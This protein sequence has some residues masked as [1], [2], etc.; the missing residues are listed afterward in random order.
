MFSYFFKWNKKI[1]SSRGSRFDRS[2]EWFFAQSLRLDHL[3][4]LIGKFLGIG[5]IWEDCF[6]LHSRNR[7]RYIAFHSI[8]RLREAQSPR[9]SIGKI[10]SYSYRSLGKVELRS[11]RFICSI[12]NDWSTPNRII[13][14]K[15]SRFLDYLISV[16]DWISKK[17]LLKTNQ[18]ILLAFS[19]G[20]DS[21]V[22][23]F[24]I[25]QLKKQW[26]WT[27]NLIWCNHLWQKDS[28]YLMFHI[29]KVNLIFY[30]K[31]FCFIN[32]RSIFSENKA[33]KWRYQIFIRAA[34][35]Y[36]LT[37]ILT[38][39]TL[40]DKIE[41]LIFNLTRGCG[42]DGFYSLNKLSFITI[43]KY[44]YIFPS[45]NL[46]KVLTQKLKKTKTFDYWTNDCAK[47]NSPN[48]VD[49]WSCENRAGGIEL[50]SICF[51]HFVSLDRTKWKYWVGFFTENKTVL[52]LS[53]HFKY[54][55]KNSK[56]ISY[57]YLIM[58]NLGDFASRNLFRRQLEL[59]QRRFPYLGKKPFA[60]IRRSSFVRSGEW[61]VDQSTLFNHKFLQPKSL[62]WGNCTSGNWSDV[63]FLPNVTNDCAKRN[64]PENVLLR[65]SKE[66]SIKRS[67]IDS[68]GS[69]KPKNFQNFSRT[70]KK[71]LNFGNW[72]NCVSSNWSFILKR[73]VSFL[74]KKS[75]GVGSSFARSH[76]SLDA[77]QPELC[78][79]AK[80]PEL[81]SG[82][83][84]SCFASLDSEELNQPLV[85]CTKRVYQ[86]TIL[87]RL[88][89]FSKSTKLTIPLTFKYA[90]IFTP[91]HRANS[92]NYYNKVL[93]MKS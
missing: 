13:Q 3:A 19:G 85:E 92:L 4:G 69:P 11:A 45:L 23:F 36:N 41:T 25:I 6:S 18:K 72:E 68:E 74:L 78:S 80:Q 17:H 70:Q 71:V 86:S 49:N 24:I 47:R 10:E 34:Y 8:N 91:F 67:L 77:K 88:A 31:T 48:H 40:T 64:S 66:Q 46:L 60:Q 83:R 21:I 12:Y 84:S 27:V 28:L 56:R 35:Y 87:Y 82:Q 16:N 55:I 43:N 79:G 42:I 7:L 9:R 15:A 38:G 30:T 53:L 54:W 26:N 81:C 90:K 75:S 65:S 57:N 37:T 1:L 89:R 76:S 50:R 61:I 51:T 2:G 22:L 33:R 14:P 5:G 29:L 73:T 63:I 93:L 44:K 32:I 52:P 20:Q 58:Q 39:H 59:T 62:N